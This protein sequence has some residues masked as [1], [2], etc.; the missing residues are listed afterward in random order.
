MISNMWIVCKS[1]R[2]GKISEWDVY[3]KE[4]MNYLY[5]C[6]SKNFELYT[7]IV[8]KRISYNRLL[9]FFSLGKGENLRMNWIESLFKI[10]GEVFRM[11]G[12]AINEN[13]NEWGVNERW[14]M[15]S[16]QRK[17]NW[18][19]SSVCV[20]IWNRNVTRRE[21]WKWILKRCLVRHMRSTVCFPF[22]KRW[23][24]SQ[25]R[26]EQISWNACW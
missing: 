6:K 4:N 5:T 21:C 18:R 16:L 2:N 15:K 13:K 7:I 1:A 24:R 17:R 23:S 14:R 26:W 22:M 19:R 11:I 25:R 3:R 8:K 12:E 10:A 20:W 9:L